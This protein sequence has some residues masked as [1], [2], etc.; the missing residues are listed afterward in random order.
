MLSIEN[1]SQNLIKSDED[2][3]GEDFVAAAVLVTEGGEAVHAGILIKYNDEYSLFH[4]SPPLELEILPA[5]QWYFHKNFNF[6]KPEEIPSFLAHCKLIKEFANPQYGYYFA[7]S[8][9]AEGQYFSEIPT[10]QYMTCVG[11]CLN[12]LNGFNLDEQ[13]ISFDEWNIG[14]VEQRY[15]DR[16]IERF[17]RDIPQISIDLLIENIRRITPTEYLAS[18]YIDEIPVKKKKIDRILVN[19]SHA[20]YNKTNP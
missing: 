9:F 10:P 20:I 3:S 15:I 19:V 2:N 12:V 5:G 13:Y 4:F 6:I 8:Y 17:R 18:A 16:I 14:T 7:G 1:I 11:F